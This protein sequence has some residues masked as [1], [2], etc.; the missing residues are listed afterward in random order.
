MNVCVCLY[1][2]VG[3]QLKPQINV[4]YLLEPTHTEANTYNRTHIRTNPSKCSLKNHTVIQS[5][6]HIHTCIYNITASSSRRLLSVKRLV[7]CVFAVCYL[8]D[9]LNDK[10]VLIVFKNTSNAINFKSPLTLSLSHTPK[11][12]ARPFTLSST[13]SPTNSSALHTF[14]RRS[15]IYVCV[16]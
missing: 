14:A 3:I 16:H 7:D 2:F 11:H 8:P 13:H 1:S 10:N 4:R 6:Q 12:S 15:F 5:A 9:W